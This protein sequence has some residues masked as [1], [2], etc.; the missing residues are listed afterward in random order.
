[1]IKIPKFNIN[2]EEWIDGKL[3]YGSFLAQGIR[4]ELGTK[5]SSHMQKPGLAVLLI[6]ED[7]ASKIYVSHKEKAADDCGFHS[8]TK[9]IPS[10]SSMDFIL[11]ILNTWNE[12]ESIHGILVQLPLPKHLNEREV[13]QAI[14]PEKD[15]DGFHFENIGRLHAKAEGTIACTPLGIMVMIQ[16]MGYDCSGKN[17]VV[18]GRSNIVGKPM[19]QLLMDV[20]QATVTICHSKTINLT[21]YVSKADILV[22]AMGVRGLVSPA[23]IK[24]GALVIDV[25]M[26]R[27]EKGVCG[28]LD[29]KLMID[30]VSYITPV[31]KGVGPMTIAMLLSNTYDNF[32]RA[33]K[34]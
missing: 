8:F 33:Q 34:G 5:V 14:S 11:S 7:E 22:S 19:A 17:A 28:D 23:M 30:N 13:L 9:R 21:D 29:Y 24:P 20:G 32:E 27:G 26:H 16:Q 6:G 4:N 1:M 15:V 18:L 2:V 3:M 10:D 25:G 31:P 12:D